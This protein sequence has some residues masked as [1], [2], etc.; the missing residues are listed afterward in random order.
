MGPGAAGRLE[1]TVGK[2]LPMFRSN[3][4]TLYRNLMKIIE[5]V[6]RERGEPAR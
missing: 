5:P 1:Q 3:A 2:Q 6:L 4:E